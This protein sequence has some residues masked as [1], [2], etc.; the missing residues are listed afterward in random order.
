[1]SLKESCAFERS[2]FRQTSPCCHGSPSWEI[3]RLPTQLRVLGSWG[4]RF[5][6]CRFAGCGVGVYIRFYREGIVVHT[7]RPLFVR[8]RICDSHFLIC[9]PSLLAVFFLS[10]AEWGAFS[11]LGYVYYT[12]IYVYMYIHILC[13]YVTPDFG[14]WKLRS[15]KCS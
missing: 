11:L 14:G 10:V 13:V 9:E 1:M 3:K 7:G 4:F 5:V 2:A 15:W 8:S 6:G 12:H